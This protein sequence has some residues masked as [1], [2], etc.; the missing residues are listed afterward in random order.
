M[1]HFPRNHLY[2]LVPALHLFVEA[3]D[4]G[5]RNS[6]IRRRGRSGGVDAARL[7]PVA[8]SLALVV[9]AVLRQKAL[10]NTK[11]RKKKKTTTKTK[12]LQ[13]ARGGVD[14][15]WLAGVGLNKI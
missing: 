11:Y 1:K 9:Q 3:L 2:V 13:G 12:Q 5:R 4:H 14:L 10:E 15:S 8:R 6:S 7:L